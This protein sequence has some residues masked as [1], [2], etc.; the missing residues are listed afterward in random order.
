[1]KRAVLIATALSIGLL[2][3]CGAPP[4]EEQCPKKEEKQQKQE[5]S[6]EKQAKKREEKRPK[7]QKET[8]QKEMKEQKQD[9]DGD[10]GVLILPRS[11]GVGF[12]I[13]GGLNILPY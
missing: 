9:E 8:K 2:S 12:P 13:G 5:S 10:E 6:H 4:S 7:Q 3:G 1:M 11:S